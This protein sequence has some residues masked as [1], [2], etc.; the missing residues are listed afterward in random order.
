MK[1]RDYVCEDAPGEIDVEC[2]YKVNKERT[3]FLRDYLR[4]CKMGNCH[5]DVMA[6]TSSE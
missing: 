4:E 5:K 1:Y 6:Q 2:N 3:E